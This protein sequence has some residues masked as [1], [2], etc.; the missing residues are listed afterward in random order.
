[1]G[2][3][4][5]KCYNCGSDVL[6]SEGSH[7]GICSFCT[8]EIPV[9]Q[10]M[11]SAASDLSRANRLLSESRFEEARE[12]YRE[13]LIQTPF[14][15]AA[16]WGFA[17]SEYG[18]EFVQD[19]NTARLLPT[20]HRLS[21]QRFSE[22]LYVKKA[23]EYAPDHETRQFYIDQSALI[24]QIQSRSLD[25]SRQEEPYDVFICYKKTEADEKRTADSRMAAD[26][27]RELVRRGY[28]TFF[29]EATLKVGEEYEPRIFAAL[30][31]ARVLL[32]IGSKEEYYEAVWVKN[33]WSRYADLIRTEAEQGGTAR[34]LI[35]VYYNLSH[36]RLPD[37]LRA[38]PRSVDMSGHANARQMIFS[39]IADHFAGGSGEDTS[40]LRRQVR[41][42]LSGAPRM[43]TSAENYVARGTIELVNQ[44]FETAE[45]MFR[46]AHEIQ[47][48]VEACLGL[49]MCA[50]G[51]AGKEALHQYDED[52]REDAWFQEALELAD[53]GKKAELETIARACLDN[54]AWSRTCAVKQRDCEAEAQA[55]LRGADGFT[56]DTPGCKTGSRMQG[57]VKEAKGWL[58][59]LN[60]E[61][62]LSI[63][64]RMFI[65]WGN[66]FPAASFFL[67]EWLHTVGFDPDIEWVII[68][69]TLAMLAFYVTFS[70]QLLGK[71]PV[72]ESGCLAV[73][74]RLGVGFSAAM[75]LVQGMNSTDISKPY[76]LIS[77]AAA[78]LYYLIRGRRRD[79]L[80]KRVRD[81]R[82][83]AG[84]ML[85]QLRA[86]EETY[87]RETLDAVRQATA[88]YEQYYR[89]DDWAAL[90]TKWERAVNDRCS[91]RM[92]TLR[93]DL[94][95][96]QSGKAEKD[97]A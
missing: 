50:R 3:V 61:S 27:Y 26:L 43:E 32:A 41:G 2:N 87:V 35:P 14:E 86:M 73:V 72:L 31:S 69:G 60:G 64:T 9:P 55:I 28:K 80:K 20:L 36:D 90:R 94:T 11:N 52:I 81:S 56:L 91:A 38:M 46:Q 8:A 63:A 1:M 58:R 37:T 7:I 68:P 15:S 45:E 24:D 77:L 70:A 93:G 30:N 42:Q 74:I 76:L 92:K 16:C 53:A 23:I 59:A 95:L 47:P 48:S 40:D 22:Y 19:P 18:I 85:R 71:L 5:L 79:K 66:L 75:L 78:I 12:L 65:Y 17:V 96:I 25:I 84:E 44:S 6:V 89:A 88:G 51:I 49:M 57:L 33:E 67:N 62:D 54:Q 82:K 10:Q 29:A 97:H 21:T 13:V 83:Q 34:L 4:T 39:L